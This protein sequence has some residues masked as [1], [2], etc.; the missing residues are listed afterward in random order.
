MIASVNLQF[1]KF[2]FNQIHYSRVTDQQLIMGSQCLLAPALCLHPT[3]W[4]WVSSRALRSQTICPFLVNECKYCIL[5]FRSKQNQDRITINIVG[6]SRSLQHRTV[7]LFRMFIWKM[8]V[9]TG[10]WTVAWR[11]EE[12]HRQIRMLLT[13]TI[14]RVGSGL[15]STV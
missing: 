5:C 4:Q 9:S 11:E 12:I 7:Q 3:L 6:L 15:S 2:T 1:P 10:R 13:K 14:P 8:K